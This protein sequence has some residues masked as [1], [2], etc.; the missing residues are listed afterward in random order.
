MGFFRYSFWGTFF[1]ST[2][3][4]LGAVYTL[5][6][7]NRIFFGNIKNLSLTSYKDLDKKEMALFTLLIFVLFLMGIFPWI[8]LD[9]MFVDCVNILEHAKGGRIVS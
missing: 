1:A 8:F 2:S 4:V 3:M 9:S 5:W 7:Y 6:T